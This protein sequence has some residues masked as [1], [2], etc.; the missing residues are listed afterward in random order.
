MYARAEP[1]KNAIAS[2]S[3]AL[4]LTAM[5]GMNMRCFIP[6]LHV[7]DFGHLHHR[8]GGEERFVDRTHIDVPALTLGSF[9]PGQVTHRGVGAL[10]IGGR[11]AYDEFT[12]E[13]ID[14][15]FRV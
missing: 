1:M 12:L 14:R 8:F 9:E 5:R 6:S 3:A 10:H 13:G 2:A 7:A 11:N 15:D 4:T